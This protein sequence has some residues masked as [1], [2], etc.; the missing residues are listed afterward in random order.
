MSLELLCIYVRKCGA[1]MMIAGIVGL[2]VAL[3]SA[4]ATGNDLQPAKQG[5]V[6]VIA[7]R[8]A[9]QGIPENTLAAYQKA[10][11][12][13]ADF[14]EIDV[15]TTRD[16]A[17]VSVHNRTVGAYTADG[18]DA[19]VAELTLA[20]LKALDIGS[21]VDSRWQD[22]RVPTLDEILEICRGK[23]SIYLDL[24]E[25]SI[26]QV[27]E[28]IRAFGM[29]KQV[30]WCVSPGEV[31][32]IKRCCPECVP[33][34]DPDSEASL[35]AMLKQCQPEVVA[36]VWRDFSA[37]FSAPCHQAGALVFVDEA[38]SDAANWSVAIEWGADGIQ[39]DDPERLIDFLKRR[40]HYRKANK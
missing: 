5:G 38:S 35:P 32:E 4:I 21:R 26:E 1:E 29:Q 12:L 37:T 9:H 28:R 19:K 7:H 40:E 11:D 39:T 20:E 30:V 3:A 24:K 15:R 22:E 27:A 17:L 2:L 34:P 13:G 10:I 25:A 36:P 14:V 16:G 31:V 8:G 18:N 6:Y 33:M 23:I